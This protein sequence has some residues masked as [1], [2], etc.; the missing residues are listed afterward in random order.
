MSELTSEELD[1][2]PSVIGPRPP[3]PTVEEFRA[4]HKCEYV[5]LFVDIGVPEE[6][7]AGWH[8]DNWE[9]IKDGSPQQAFDDEVSYW[10]NDGE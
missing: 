2:S 10:E 3:M 9:D 4:A 7:A 8:D 6:V 1:D 5:R